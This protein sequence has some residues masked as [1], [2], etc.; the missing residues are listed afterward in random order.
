MTSLFFLNPG[1][2]RSFLAWQKV[3]GRVIALGKS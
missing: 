3:Y 1:A 2:H